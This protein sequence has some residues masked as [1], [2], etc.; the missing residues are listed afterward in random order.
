MK[1][2]IITDIH[3]NLTAL[4]AV[5][6]AL[7]EHGCSKMVCCG[8]IIG[9]GPYPQETVQYMKRISDLVAVRGNHEKYLICGLPN[10][11]P[12]REEMDD[13]EI[14]YHKWEHSL[15]SADSVRFLEALPYRKDF[16]C[17][18]LTVSV[19]HYAMNDNGDYVSIV[20]EPTSADLDSVF[21][22]VS[23]DIVIFGHDHKRCICRG[24]KL[25]VNVGSLG[26]PAGDKSIARAGILEINDGDAKI[27]TVDVKY[28]VDS[29]LKDIDTINYPAA[30]I[31]KKYFFGI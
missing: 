23:S 16:I 8:D 14:A 25:Y 28:D 30:H 2:G 10:S 26:C 11:S 21:S 13:E 7:T 24:D 5:I 6:E 3:N 19:M 29:V 31:I 17:E 1:I 4:T 22:Q 20:K 9:I 27:R 12:G 15:L 18:G